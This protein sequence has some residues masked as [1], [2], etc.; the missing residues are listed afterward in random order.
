[1]IREFEMRN[2]LM[3]KRRTTGIN[4]H[5]A[6]FMGL[7]HIGAVAVFFDFSWQA[8]VDAVVLSLISACLVVGISF[9]R[10]LTHRGY[11]TP[12]IVEYFLTFCV[13]LALEGGP[14]IWVVSLRIHHA[15]EDAPGDP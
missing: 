15:H 9:H 2:E 1:M 3:N 12:R 7:L 10:L 5:T 8:L 4:W 13:T 6:I 11:K 14:I